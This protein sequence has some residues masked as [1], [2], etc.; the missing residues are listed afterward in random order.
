MDEAVGNKLE[1]GT[2]SGFQ[3]PEIS[4]GQKKGPERAELSYKASLF[5]TFFLSFFFFSDA[6]TMTGEGNGN[7]LEYSCLENPMD[8]G[9]WWA[10]VHG[11]A[12]SWT[13]LKRL[14]THAHTM[15]QRDEK[16]VQLCPQLLQVPDLVL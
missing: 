13:R 8:R 7:P 15:S 2:K 3:R 9:A 11:F 6:C 10:T 14:S 16:I 1:D 4:L 5:F 12:K